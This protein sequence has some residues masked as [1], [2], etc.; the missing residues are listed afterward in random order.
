MYS[1]KIYD[2]LVER[3]L[4]SD[5][6]LV[7]RQAQILR[8]TRRETYIQKQSNKDFFTLLLILAYILPETDLLSPCI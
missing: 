3:I 4:K 6:G 2:V 1:G 7:L 5:Q 8:S